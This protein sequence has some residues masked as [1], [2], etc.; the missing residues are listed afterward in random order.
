[1]WAR[2]E[3]EER[4]TAKALSRRKEEERLTDAAF[5][6]KMEAER[7]AVE[8][9]ARK[10]E[11]EHLAA[12]ALKRR[13]E[14]E[15]LGAQA[16]AR[17]KEEER[18]I[19]EAVV[20]KEQA[21]RLATE[22]RDSIAAGQKSQYF[23]HEDIDTIND[24]QAKSEMAA[25]HDELQRNT[26]KVQR[27]SPAQIE[28]DMTMVRDQPKRSIGDKT[29]VARAQNE[30]IAASEL[31]TKLSE[32]ERHRKFSSIRPNDPRLK[33]KMRR[34]VFRAGGDSDED[35]EDDD[36]TK[37]SSSNDNKTGKASGMVALQKVEKDNISTF[38]LAT[39]RPVIIAAA[40][41]V[42]GRRLLSVIGKAV[43]L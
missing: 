13:K 30:S 7:L 4:L 3:E 27:R 40:A 9:S 28:S 36:S 10:E 11:E 20:M 14:E 16:L 17:R 5:S 22:I 2:K 23:E 18:L 37:E 31:L 33:A 34:P 12:V 6:V 43:F 1:V 24:D 29:I 38:S 39:K 41:F 26:D 19:A 15:R 21:Q 8:A 32:K 42:I 35:D 25:F